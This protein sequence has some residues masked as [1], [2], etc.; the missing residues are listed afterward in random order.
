MAESATGDGQLDAQGF[1]GDPS[2]GHR[3]WCYP[4]H[5]RVVTPRWDTHSSPDQFCTNCTVMAQHRGMGSVVITE[6]ICRGHAIAEVPDLDA[7]VAMMVEMGFVEDC[8][9]RAL[10]SVDGSVERAL[11]IAAKLAE[12]GTLRALPRERRTSGE[13]VEWWTTVDG[14]SSLPEYRAALDAIAVAPRLMRSSINAETLDGLRAEAALRGLGTDAPIE[15]WKT[16]LAV[17]IAAAWELPDV[18]AA[19]Q[20][21]VSVPGVTTRGGLIFDGCVKFLHSDGGR[22]PLVLAALE[23]LGESV[24]EATADEAA[25]AARFRLQMT[26]GYLK[27]GA[28]ECSARRRWVF[29]QIASAYGANVEKCESTSLFFIR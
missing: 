28:D 6:Y 2:R 14:E 13:M 27:R 25:E 7:K 8:A 1:H 11:D 23:L 16:R 17:V 21:R 10:R 15:V 5:R 29:D 12:Y 22:A 4:A 26:L 20:L 3:F 9:R 24:A 18:A 19:Q